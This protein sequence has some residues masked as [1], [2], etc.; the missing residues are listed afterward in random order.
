MPPSKGGPKAPFWRS[1]KLCNKKLGV[2]LVLVKVLNPTWVDENYDHE[3]SG[4]PPP[5]DQRELSTEHKPALLHGAGNQNGE[6]VDKSTLT[7]G[8]SITDACIDWD[9]TVK[10]LRQLA[11]A[12]EKRRAL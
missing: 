4:G 7:Y 3:G 6:G 10:V 9:D 1:W 11:D 8:Q 2:V 5:P 12:V